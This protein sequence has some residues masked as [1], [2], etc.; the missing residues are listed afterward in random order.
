[1]KIATNNHFAAKTIHMEMF[2]CIDETI[3]LNDAFAY[4]INSPALQPIC[5]M[6]VSL[7]FIATG[8]NQIQKE[9]QSRTFPRVR[10]NGGFVVISKK[11]QYLT[12]KLISNSKKNIKMN[13]V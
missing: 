3:R 12:Q 4:R 6:H 8:L 2:M 11:L 1:M 5:A 13:N 7:S 10:K 9:M